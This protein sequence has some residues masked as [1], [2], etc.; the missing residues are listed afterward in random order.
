MAD[1]LLSDAAPTTHL[2]GCRW[3]WDGSPCLCLGQPTAPTAD[4]AHRAAIL[5]ADVK[6]LR[7]DIVSLTED[8][9]DLLIAKTASE[10]SL[11]VANA[12]LERIRAIWWS[13]LEVELYGAINAHLAAQ[14]ATAP[15]RTEPTAIERMFDDA[16]RTEAAAP[17][18]NYVGRCNSS[19][20]PVHGQPTAPTR[21]EAE[22]R[23]LDAMARLRTEWL[24]EMLGSDQCFPNNPD[25]VARV[26]L[27]EAELA[28]REAPP[29]RP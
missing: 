2:P 16:A 28:R 8:Y 27:H 23:V 10:S 24:Q 25:C 22:Q 21:T 3:A 7:A 26:A 4:A 11:A 20:C 9:S 6:R 13:D 17:E 5:R 15:T 1:E 19:R 14:P 29:R 18:C 12:L